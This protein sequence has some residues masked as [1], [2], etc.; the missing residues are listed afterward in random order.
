MRNTTKASVRIAG[1]PA[2]IRRE[3]LPN[4]S[5][6]SP[7]SKAVTDSIFAQLNFFLLTLA[8]RSSEVSDAVLA[9]K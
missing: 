2:K 1:A 3:H 9:S 7:M 5:T 6:A 4:T 8:A